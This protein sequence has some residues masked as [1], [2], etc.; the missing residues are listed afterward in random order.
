MD[1]IYCTVANIYSPAQIYQNPQKLIYYGWDDI[2]VY[3]CY[4]NLEHIAHWLHVSACELSL[5]F[6]P[7]LNIHVCLYPIGIALGFHMSKPSQSAS[8]HYIPNCLHACS[9][10]QFCARL[11]D[12]PHLHHL[13]LRIKPSLTPHVLA[14]V[15]QAATE[16][17]SAHKMQ[18]SATRNPYRQ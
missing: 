1:K 12:H 10:P 14:P 8:S 7:T 16:N 5:H 2:M 15:Q 17:R 6:P 11:P 9:S 3:P 4:I 18:T 13:Q